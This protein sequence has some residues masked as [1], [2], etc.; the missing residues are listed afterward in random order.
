MAG[1]A[2]RKNGAYFLRFIDGEGE[3][4]TRPLASITA[5]DAKDFERFIKSHAR[6]IGKPAERESAAAR[7]L[8]PETVRKRISNAKQFFGDAVA[9]ELIARNPFADLKSSVRGNRARD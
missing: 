9:R 7:G 2:K 5:G 3:R 6:M 1:I 8:N 4:R